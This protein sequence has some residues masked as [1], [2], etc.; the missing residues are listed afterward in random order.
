MAKLKQRTRIRKA[1]ATTVPGSK[2]TPQ[3]RKRRPQQ[4]IKF[5][6]GFG[7]PLDVEDI[8]KRKQQF[9]RQQREN[10]Q[11]ARSIVGRDVARGRQA[12]RRVTFKRGQRVAATR[13]KQFAEF[14]ELEVIREMNVTSSWVA[15][16]HLVIVAG[17]PALAIT[18]RSGFVAMYPTTNIRDYETMSAAA[19]KG[20][21]IW[22]TLYFGIPGAGVPYQEI[23]FPRRR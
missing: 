10:K 15:S 1:S 6:V 4:K 9:E 5:R 12:V 2:A 7:K 13:L 11:I 21:Y 18:F 22:R 14:G 23:A 16:I 17:E 20:G 19:S 8:A 3:A